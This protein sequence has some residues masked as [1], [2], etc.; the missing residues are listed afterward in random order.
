LGCYITKHG[1]LSRNC[2]FIKWES[3]AT[4]YAHRGSYVFLFSNQFIEVHSII[5]G[6]LVQV[7]EAKDI[8]LLSSGPVDAIT[9]NDPVLVA[10]RGEKDDRDGASDKIVEFLETNEIAQP[11]PRQPMFSPGVWDEWDM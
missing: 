2:G 5:T 3:K 7:Y 8:R 10:M 9:G 11:G 4:S 6:R 1:S